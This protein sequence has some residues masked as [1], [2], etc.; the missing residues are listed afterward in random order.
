VNGEKSRTGD[1]N[2]DQQCNRRRDL[3]SYRR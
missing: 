1:G 3:H 2:R